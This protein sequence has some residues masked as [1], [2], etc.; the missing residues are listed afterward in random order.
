MN[1]KTTSKEIKSVPNIYHALNCSK[2]NESACLVEDVHHGFYIF[3]TPQQC[4]IITTAIHKRWANLSAF[5]D[6]N[7]QT[8]LAYHDEI[9][10]SNPPEGQLIEVT[11]RYVWNALFPRAIDRRTIAIPVSSSGRKSTIGLCE[12]RPGLSTIDTGLKTP[13]AHTCLT[14]FNECIT[15]NA[16]KY[17]PKDPH[18]SEATLRK[19][20]EDNAGR[21]HTKQD[22]WRIFQYY[23]PLLISE[24]L[25]IRK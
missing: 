7:K 9:F 25:I 6:E 11:A 17:P 1:K 21:L 18:I 10:K 2:E 8:I 16:G 5:M 14:L 19:Y 3:E 4:H 12:Y 20:I 15:F 22:P 13:Q 24:K 23:R